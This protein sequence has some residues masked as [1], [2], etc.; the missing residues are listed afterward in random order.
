MEL[1]SAILSNIAVSVHCNSLVSISIRTLNLVLLLLQGAT[2]NLGNYGTVAIEDIIV[3]YIN[4]DF[5]FT[6][7][8]SAAFST[9][10]SGVYVANSVTCYSSVKYH[11]NTFITEQRFVNCSKI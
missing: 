7:I 3:N 2:F 11:C 9:N 4:I 5:N 6:L 8:K 10:H 1:K